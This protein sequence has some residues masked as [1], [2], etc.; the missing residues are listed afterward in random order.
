MRL[1][2]SE[3]RNKPLE[4]F[5]VGFYR[6]DFA[7]VDFGDAD[8]TRRFALYVTAEFEVIGENDII[9]CLFVTVELL[10]MRFIV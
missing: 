7:T 4:V 5:E 2:G 8:A 1:S 10:F 9:Y 6:Y 3:L